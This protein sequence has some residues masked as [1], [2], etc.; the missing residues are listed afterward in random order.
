LPHEQEPLRAPTLPPWPVPPA[1]MPFLYLWL[2]W[3]WWSELHTQLG[4]LPE[5]V[6]H[7]GSFA[8]AA[9]AARALSTLT[10]SACYVLWW[11]SLGGRLRYWRFTSWIAT[12][13]G[14]DLVGFALRRAAEGSGDGMRVL[15][16]VIVGPAVLAAPQPPAAGP[17]TAFGSVGV[18]T[19]SRIVLTAWAQG[20][21]LGRGI[22]GPLVLTSA[23]WLG[24]RL[25]AWWSLDLLQGRSPVR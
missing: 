8:A 15:G 13:S 21:G 16:A 12:L 1:G 5:P 23:A 9:L 17:M 2:V 20:R 11:R 18:F 3:A 10:E 19:L 24:T 4:T 7:V 6:N 25:V 22:T 14:I